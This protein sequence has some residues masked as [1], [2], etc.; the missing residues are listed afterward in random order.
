MRREHFGVIGQ[1]EQFFKNGIVERLGEPHRFFLGV[2]QIGTPDI[3]D[4]QCITGEYAMQA[5][6]PPSTRKLMLSGECPGV[7][8][9]LICSE[10]TRTTWPSLAS[11]CG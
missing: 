1:G 11:V 5:R 2:A 7:S 3:A 9:H 6:R 10:P 8:R 4:K